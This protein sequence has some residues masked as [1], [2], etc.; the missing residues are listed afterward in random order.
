MAK[1]SM[2]V[3]K[4]IT[5]GEELKGIANEF[6]KIIDE[7]YNKI[8]KVSENGAIVSED[9]NGAANVLIR[10]AQE[11]KKNVSIVGTNMYKLGDKLIS[12]ANEIKTTSND[13]IGG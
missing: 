5:N 13:T 8:I 3:E 9:E 11:D 1:L 7:T 12:Y 2:N 6:N 4:I 10:S